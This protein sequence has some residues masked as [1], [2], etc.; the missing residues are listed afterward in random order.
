MKIKYIIL[1]LIILLVPTFVKAS[2]VD[3][4]ITNYYIDS[5]ILE[6]GDLEIKELIVLNGSFNGY[7]RELATSNS[8][9]SSSN[10]IDFEHDAIYNASGIY[11]MKIGA[12]KIKN[13]SFDT[14]NEEFEALE[15]SDYSSSN[16]KKTVV[17]KYN[18]YDEYKMYYRSNNESVAFLLDYKLDKAI[19]LHNDVAELYWQFIGNDFTDQINDLKIRIHLPNNDKSDSF[20][21]WAHG[22]L[23]GEIEKEDS[24]TVYAYV[25]YLYPNSPVDIRINFDKNLITDTSKVKKSNE[26]ALDSILKVE[27]ERALEANRIR[28]RQ[29]KIAAIANYTGIFLIV[30]QIVNIIYI[31][32]KHDKEY[33]SD[34]NND[35]YRE[36]FDD[37]NVEVGDYILKRTI[38]P[39]AMSASIMNLIYKKNIKAEKIEVEEGKKENYE[40]TLLNKDNLSDTETKLV[41]FLFEKVGNNNKFTTE[42]LKK[43]AK[44]TKTYS[45][46]NNT[47]TSWKNSVINDGKKLKIF[48]TSIPNKIF[49][50]LFCLLVMFI[51]II[52]STNIGLSIPYVIATILSIIVVIYSLQVLKRTKYGNEQYLRLKASKK[53]LLDFGAFD[54]KELP[55][56]SLWE[57]YM[58]Y[59]TLFGIASKVSKTMNVKIQEISNYESVQTFNTSYYDFELCNIINSSISS[60][61]SMASHTA[62]EVAASSMSSSSGSGGGF[63]SGGGFGG[64]GGGGHGF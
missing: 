59:A 41:N 46:F 7:I 21:V 25:K 13:V 37:F 17:T 52:F 30:F 51:G 56:I 33:K 19:V 61:V 8:V 45:D 63:S 4:E 9:L 38:T 57:R 55:E 53:F 2:D 24:K 22:D 42:E 62:M 49:N 28:K 26:E 14:F 29:Q 39:N 58:V 60:A 31:Y 50:V 43:Y 35:Y 40:F 47:Y 5:Y 12:K 1:S 44:S 32:F 10:K 20:R 54:I 36:F 15:T 16:S 64:G 34:F 11:D 6:N 23:T 48:E 27:K 18:N 3:Y